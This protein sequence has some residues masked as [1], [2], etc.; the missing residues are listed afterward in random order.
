MASPTGIEGWGALAGL[1]MGVAVGNMS[2]LYVVAW[3]KRADWDRSRGGGCKR[4]G[5]CD[6]WCGCVMAR[7]CVHVVV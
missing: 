7:V 1:G 4:V 6:S 5:V 2:G 3:V